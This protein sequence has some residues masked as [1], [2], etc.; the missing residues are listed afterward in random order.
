MDLDMPP[1]K[2][3]S[4]AGHCCSQSLIQF[5]IRN[6]ERLFEFAESGYSGSRITLKAKNE[7]QLRRAYEEARSF[8]LPCWLFIDKDHIL[9]PHFTGAPI[10]TGLG[11]G[12][13]TREA[14][15]PITKRF[16]CL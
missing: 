2:L 5:L 9:P 7:A 3:A 8:D 6:P 14:M 16:Q 12:P 13:A 1:G 15:R 4:Q 10:V 11:I